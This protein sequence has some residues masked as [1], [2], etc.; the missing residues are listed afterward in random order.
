MVIFMN[1]SPCCFLHSDWLPCATLCLKIAMKCFFL[2]F[3]FFLQP[4]EQWTTTAALSFAFLDFKLFVLLLIQEAQH[5]PYTPWIRSYRSWV[6]PFMC[7]SIPYMRLHTYCSNFYTFHFWILRFSKL[8]CMPEGGG[9]DSWNKMKYGG[10][11]CPCRN[12]CPQDH[13]CTFS[14]M[15][16]LH[17]VCNQ[18]KQGNTDRL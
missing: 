15:Y 16:W 17:H 13:Q 9:A 6:S 10:P 3:F 11:R 18:S 8:H 14:L 12:V 1:F 4:H 7:L 2:Y 5:V